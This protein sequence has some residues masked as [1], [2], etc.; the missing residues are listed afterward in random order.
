MAA[1]EE[2]AE[3]A[4]IVTWVMNGMGGAAC[5]LNLLCCMSVSASG[6]KVVE[7]RRKSTGLR[8]EA[9]GGRGV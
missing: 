6:K 2:E 5:R 9:S 4:T 3:E 7:P 1:M 8:R